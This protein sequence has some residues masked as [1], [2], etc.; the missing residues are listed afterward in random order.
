IEVYLSTPLEICEKRDTEGLYQKVRL[1]K[2]KNFTGISHPY[3]P[4]LNPEIEL[5]TDKESIS[6]S[7]NRVIRYLIKNGY[8]K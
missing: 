5:R 4:P 8:L 6:Q 3:E 2:I 1:G 7:V